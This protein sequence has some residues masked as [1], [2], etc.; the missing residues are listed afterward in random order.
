MGEL[1]A[2]VLEHT[3]GV[4]DG[5][6]RGDGWRIYPAWLVPDGAAGVPSSI[7]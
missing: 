4:L 7:G 5:E 1:R 3:L 2:R 6:F